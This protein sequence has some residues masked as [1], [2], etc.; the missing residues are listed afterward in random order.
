MAIQSRSKRPPKVRSRFAT[1][2]ITWLWIA[3]GMILLLAA[4]IFAWQAQ[5]GQAF[6]MQEGTQ[7]LMVLIRNDKEGRYRVQYAGIRPADLRSLH[8]RLAGQVL[9]VDVKQVVLS[10]DGQEVVLQPNGRLPE[11]TEFILQPND[12]FDVLVTFR[13]QTLGGNY[14]NGFRIVYAVSDRERTYDLVVDYDYTIVVQ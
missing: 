5:A 2:R 12:T 1:R 4:V 3:L 6:K 7:N 11:G 10:R 14:M 9:H 8:V 13:G